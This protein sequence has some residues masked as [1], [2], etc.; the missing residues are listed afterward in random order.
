MDREAKKIHFPSYEISLNPK[1][2]LERCPAAV[3]VNPPKTPLF[4][5]PLLE[6]GTR[7]NFLWAIVDLI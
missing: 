3:S 5:L 4:G 7:P 2:P 1:N 6:K